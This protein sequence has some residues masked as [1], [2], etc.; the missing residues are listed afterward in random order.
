MIFFAQLVLEKLLQSNIF[1]LCL[2]LLLNPILSIKLRVIRPKI[3]EMIA[4][5]A[6]GTIFTPKANRT[7]VLLLLPSIAFWPARLMS[8]D[9][10][11]PV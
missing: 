1:E 8:S 4:A 2:S 11:I 7:S 3:V 10:A 5:P 6:I 9:V